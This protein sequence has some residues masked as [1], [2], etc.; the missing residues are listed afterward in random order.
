MSVK[1]T[2][3]QRDFL[4]RHKYGVVLD[5]RDRGPLG[6]GL[7]TYDFIGR[8]RDAGLIEIVD[9]NKSGWPYSWEGTLITDLGRA[10]LAHPKAP[11][12]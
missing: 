7:P 1:L 12:K 4:L 6:H 8:C 10:A 11:S 3:P 2:K 5:R 9:G